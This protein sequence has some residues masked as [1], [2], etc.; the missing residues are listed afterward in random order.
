MFL[1]PDTAV[2]YIRKYGA[3]RL[4]YGSDY[5]LWDPVVEV[6]RFLSL[7]LTDAEFEQIAHKTAED[8]LGI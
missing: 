8:L 1:D 6:E 7:K 5:P 4:V 3:E 2:D